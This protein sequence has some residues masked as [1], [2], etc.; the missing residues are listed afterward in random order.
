MNYNIYD[1]LFIVGILVPFGLSRLWFRSQRH[2]QLLPLPPGPR[3]LPI[4]GNLLDMIAA[5]ETDTLE[6]WKYEYGE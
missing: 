6:K 3:G 1:L 4:V 5:R 2:K